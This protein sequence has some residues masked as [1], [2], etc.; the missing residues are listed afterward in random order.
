MGKQW[1]YTTSIDVCVVAEGRNAEYKWIARGIFHSIH[2]NTCESLSRTLSKFTVYS[3]QFLPFFRR[4]LVTLLS[5]LELRQVLVASKLCYSKR[6][7]TYQSRLTVARSHW[8]VS[9]CVR[10][11]VA[12][13]VLTMLCSNG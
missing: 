7:M 1:Q 10:V 2:P 4:W 11:A 6:M 5:P 12:F 9:M 8:C 3:T 13:A